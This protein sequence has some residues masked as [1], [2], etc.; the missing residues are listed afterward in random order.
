MSAGREATA[1][2]RPASRAW[3]T[4]RTWLAWRPEWPAT[5]LVATAWVLL[6][7]MSLA[8][9]DPAPPSAVPVHAGHAGHAGPTG[10]RA[11]LAYAVG[12]GL[13]AVMSIA[14]MVPLTLPAVRHVAFN[15]LRARRTRAIGVYLGGFIAPWVAVG[16]AALALAGLLEGVVGLDSRGLFVAALAIAAVWQLTPI[17]RRALYACRRTV[18]LPPLGRRADAACARF[19]L[20]Q[21]GRCVLV[22]GPLMA[23]MAFVSG[24]PLAL[25]AGLTVLSLG[26][27]LPL[28]GPRL[29][30]PIAMVLT[31]AAVLVALVPPGWWS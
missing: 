16:I 29:I 25:M 1:V 24:H 30:R 7:W 20:L 13:W 9:V 28:V 22:C 3:R 31:G 11:A 5:L 26:E 27:A 19:G 18:P 21:G 12:V 8:P 2:A 6:T 4:G 17:K 10:D 15:S 14:M 23:S